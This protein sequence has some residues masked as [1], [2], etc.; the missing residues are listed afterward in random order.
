MA[1]HS[2]G[3]DSS[4]RLRTVV[5]MSRHYLTS[6]PTTQEHVTLLAVLPQH[7]PQRLAFHRRAGRSLSPGTTSNTLAACPF[8]RTL[9][10]RP[11][12]SIEGTSTASC[13]DGPAITMTQRS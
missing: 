13:F 4:S 11:S 2:V 5:D 8:T 1:D 10:M 3:A 9:P 12:A 7:E 6:T